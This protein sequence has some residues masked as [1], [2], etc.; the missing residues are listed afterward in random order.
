MDDQPGGYV[1]VI[2][3]D[4]QTLVLRGL[5]PDQVS[6]TSDFRSQDWISLIFIAFSHSEFALH[7]LP[8]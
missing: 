4:Y 3:R 1:D 2:D 6:F 7:F 8:P 5:K